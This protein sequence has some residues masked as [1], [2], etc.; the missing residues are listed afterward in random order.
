[1][2]DKLKFVTLITVF[3]LSLGLLYVATTQ[4]GRL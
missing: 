3:L 4:L 2:S 1:M